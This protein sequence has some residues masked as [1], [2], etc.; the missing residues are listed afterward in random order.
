MRLGGYTL[1][2]NMGADI[3]PW[4]KGF[5]LKTQGQASSSNASAPPDS[6]VLTEKWIS[7]WEPAE[8]E[9]LKLIS[10]WQKL[11]CT[12]VFSDIAQHVFGHEQ[13]GIFDPNGRPGLE[14]VVGKNKSSQEFRLIQTKTGLWVACYNDKIETAELS[15]I[16][17]SLAA[18]PFGDPENFHASHIERVIYRSTSTATWGEGEQSFTGLEILGTLTMNSESIESS[19]FNVK[20]Q[21][22]KLKRPQ[23]LEV[24]LDKQFS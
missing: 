8:K 15:T 16:K 3:P 9:A 23:D 18:L 21:L 19:H 7:R 24:I 10:I 22:S 11:D 1:A 20:I 4:L 17:E 12:R 5:K 2:V 14:C 6:K 13:I